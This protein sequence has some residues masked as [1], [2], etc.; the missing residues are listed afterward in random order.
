M[1]KISIKLNKLHLDYSPQRKIELLLKTCKIIYDSMSV[2]A[3]GQNH[4]R[5][6]FSFPLPSQWARSKQKKQGTNTQEDGV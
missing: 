1:E 5:A 3:P 6:S 2:S 4:E